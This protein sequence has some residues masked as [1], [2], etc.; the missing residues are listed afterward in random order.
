MSKATSIINWSKEDAELEETIRKLEPLGLNIEICGQWVWVHGDTKPHART[1]RSAGLK[2]SS[3]KQAWY[4]IPQALRGRPW[5]PSS[6]S[7]DMSTIRTA[8]GSRIVN[9]LR[10]NLAALR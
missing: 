2:W 9:H 7:W 6:Q 10:R 3:K 4:Y 1:L 8:H 5:Q